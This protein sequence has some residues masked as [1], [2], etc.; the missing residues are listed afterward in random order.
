MGREMF[1]A[2]RKLVEFIEKNIKIIAMI[3][4][5]VLGLV[6]RFSL[7]KVE[8][9]DYR[10]FLELWFYEIK[11]NGGL[12]GLGTSVGNYNFLYQTLIA[13][14][15][16]IP[17]KCLYSYKLLSVIFDV[18]L[19]FSV[20]V[21]VKNILSGG[22]NDLKAVASWAL[23]WLVPTF[24]LNSAA[25][26]QCDSIYSTFLVL[27]LYYLQKESK[28]HEQKAFAFFGLALAFKLQAVFLLPFILFYWFKKKD[29]SILNIL[30]SP[31]V[32][33][34]TGLPCLIAGRPIGQFFSLYKEQVTEYSARLSYSYPGIWQIFYQPAD[35][36]IYHNYRMA[37]MILAVCALGFLMVLWTTKKYE[38]T[39]LN[40][41][42]MAFLLTFTAVMFLPAMHERY[43]YVYMIL[44]AVIA[45]M[46]KKTI[47]AYAT[48]C[49]I[50]L[51]TYSGYINEYWSNFTF[52]GV[53]CIAFVNVGVYVWYIIDLNKT[54]E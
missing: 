21:Y 44:G 24:F 34:A 10:D 30:I 45:V 5:G 2:E 9:P 35:Y 52:F 37:A 25:W 7:F 33:F 46:N 26:S 17:I 16:M 50:D 11:G 43:G 51:I 18:T 27:T 15:T 38:M 4:A 40:A 39:P 42:Y 22:E 12:R 49:V 36:E 28:Y 14:L 20:W 8:S 48:L 47:P 19:A 3:L 1:K 53:L 13:I 54:M 32:L 29:F 41:L 6:I 31:V 23:M